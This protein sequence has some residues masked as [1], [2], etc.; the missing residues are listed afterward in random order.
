MN[1][2]E[3]EE[4]TVLLKSCLGLF[5]LGS[6]MLYWWLLPQLWLFIFLVPAVRK[7][8]HGTRYTGMILCAELPSGVSRLSKAHSSSFTASHPHNNSDAIM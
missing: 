6:M 7:G 3:H 5:G 8:G 2:E 4:N 1:T